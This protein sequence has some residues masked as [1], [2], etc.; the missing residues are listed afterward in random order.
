MD[1]TICLKLGIDLSFKLILLNIIST[2]S[3]S[4]TSFHYNKRY[5]ANNKIG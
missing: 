2:Y 4:I 5:M 1:E 3:E